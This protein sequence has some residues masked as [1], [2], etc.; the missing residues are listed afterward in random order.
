MKK[1]RFLVAILTAAVMMVTLKSGCGST[2]SSTSSEATVADSAP[3]AASTVAATTAPAPVEKQIT[4]GLS[5][6]TQKEERW[7][8]EAKFFQDAVEKLGAKVVIQDAN[9]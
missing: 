4:I 5:L 8:K 2:S 1:M 7:S 6:A 9:N 3:A